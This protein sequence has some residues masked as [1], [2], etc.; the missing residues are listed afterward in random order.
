MNMLFEPHDINLNLYR[1][2]NWFVSPKYDFNIVCVTK[3]QESRKLSYF[4]F[5]LSIKNF[6][7]QINT[8]TRENYPKSEYILFL[9]YIFQAKN[10]IYV[11]RHPLAFDFRFRGNFMYAW[12][13]VSYMITEAVTDW[14]SN[15]W[16]FKH[17]N[18]LFHL[19]SFKYDQCQRY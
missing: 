6:K 14:A 10:H 12:L 13:I 5:Y 15:F 17:W 9:A 1:D 16:E 7:K 2:H 8:K 4:T 18:A 11:F 19:N 3:I